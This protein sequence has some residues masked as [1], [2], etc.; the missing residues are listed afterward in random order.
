MQQSWYY[1]RIILILFMV[2]SFSQGWRG[3]NGRGSSYVKKYPKPLTTQTSLHLWQCP[4]PAKSLFPFRCCSHGSP[5][6][7]L[8]CH[9]IMG[10]SR[11][12]KCGAERKHWRWPMHS[13]ISGAQTDQHKCVALSLQ[14][15]GYKSINSTIP[16]LQ[17]RV[18]VLLKH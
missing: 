2:L 17:P 7:I 4:H 12:D 6:T 10:G 8:R 13:L 15:L 11:A 9:L 3:T 1:K 16:Q 5:H 14:Y 18:P